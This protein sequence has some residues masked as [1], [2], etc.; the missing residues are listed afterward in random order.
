MPKTNTPKTKAAKNNNEPRQ[1]A[2][3]PQEWADLKA[4]VRE[5]VERICARYDDQEQAESLLL[6][7]DLMCNQDY[8]RLDRESVAHVATNHAFT[9]TNAFYTAQ[10]ICFQKV[11]Q[12]T[13]LRM[14]A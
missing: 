13:E 14:V 2:A 5:H 8:D 6:L 12:G 11:P 4:L 3:N 7:I 1:L 10:K 9:F